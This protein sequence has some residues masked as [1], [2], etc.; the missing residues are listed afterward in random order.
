MLNFVELVIVALIL[1]N[2]KE[3]VARFK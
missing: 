1:T 3:I 2:V